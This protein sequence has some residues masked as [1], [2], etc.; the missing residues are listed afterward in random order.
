MTNIIPELGYYTNVRELNG[1]LCAVHPFLFTWAICVGINMEGNE[2]KT[3]YCY[4][5]Q[6]DAEEAL[7]EWDGRGDPPGPWIK[8]KPE[9]RSNPNRK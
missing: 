3:R 5:K 4:E 7:A 1:N 8:Q 6:E 9:D 2:H